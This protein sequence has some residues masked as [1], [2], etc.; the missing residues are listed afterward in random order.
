MITN[1]TADTSA[2]IER[3]LDGYRRLV[4]ML[5]PARP[6]EILESSV[7]MAQM[8][9]LWLLSAVSE[10]RMSELAVSLHL[11]MSTISGLVDRLVESG[12]VARRTDEHDRRQ[13]MVS[14][15]VDGAAFFDRFQELGISHLRDLLALLTPA[16]MTAVTHA[17]ELLME[18]AE[19]LPKEDHS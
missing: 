5:A 16:E 13:V 15:T 12:L 4:Q 9:V 10:S 1:E 17:L 6:T 2:Q 8:K 18:A 11:S 14:L 3:T 7:T 19:R